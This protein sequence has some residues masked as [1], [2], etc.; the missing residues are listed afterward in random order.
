MN[1]R[2]SP[3]ALLVLA[4]CLA[5]AGCGTYASN[6]VRDLHE[7][8]L[9]EYPLDG[10]RPV[11]NPALTSESTVTFGFNVLQL[12]DFVLGWFGLDPLDDDESSGEADPFEGE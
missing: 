2:A 9:Y 7:C 11:D 3:V 1:R 4:S 6:R 8:L 12:A 5:L 10:R